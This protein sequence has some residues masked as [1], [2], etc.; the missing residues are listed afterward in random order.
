MNGIIIVLWRVFCRW[1][2]EVLD[3]LKNPAN[4][5]VLVAPV[6]IQS[7][8]FGYAATYDLNDAP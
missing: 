4:R 1:R 5:I 6:I 3:L 7:V 2:K 8:V